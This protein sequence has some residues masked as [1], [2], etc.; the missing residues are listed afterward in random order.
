MLLTML[1]ADGWMLLLLDAADG[2]LLVQVD[3]H[4]VK[5]LQLSVSRVHDEM[6]CHGL[7]VR[8][9]FSQYDHSDPHKQHTTHEM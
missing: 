8:P 2:W 3:V 9:H 7:W 4:G 5:V 1:T 6:E